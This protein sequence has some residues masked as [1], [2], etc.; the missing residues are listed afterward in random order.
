MAHPNILVLMADQLCQDALGCYGNELI[1]TPNIDKLAEA[2]I[3]FNNAYCSTPI[4]VPSRMSFITG[5]RAA[6]HHW[7]TNSP[8]PGPIPELPTMMTILQRAGYH[9]QGIG[10]M[11]FFG[12]MYGFQ[13]LQRMEE[14]VEFRAD[15]DY[16]LYLKEN[17]IRTR[18]PQGL[19]DLL[20]YQPQ[21]CGIPEEHSQSQ[22]V[23]NQSVEF[24]RNHQKQR[25]GKPFLLWSS[26][27]AP[28]PPFAPCEPYDQM[29]KPEDFPLP[30]N[31]ERPISSIPVPA[32]GHRSRLENA[33][34]DSARIQRIRALYAGQVSQVDNC[35]G[36]ILD[37]LEI[38]GLAQ[39]TVILFVSDHGD[40]LG[41][42]GLSQKNVPYNG[43]IKIPMLLKWPGKS[44]PGVKCENLVGIED[45]LP[46]IID[47]LE[48]E[49]DSGVGELPG[50]SLLKIPQ[51]RKNYVIDYGSDE[52]RWIA[53]I[54]KKHKYV[55]WLCGGYEELYDI[56]NDPDEIRNIIDEQPL[57]AK[58]MQKL[59]LEWEKHWGLKDSIV[60]NKF[61]VLAT[62][63]VE[64]VPRN[65]YVNEG[66]WP[67][68]LPEEEQ[69]SV[70]TYGEA[71]T[72]AI[73]KEAT[74]SPEKLSIDI[75]KKHGGHA[76]I[77]TPWEN[78]WK[79][80]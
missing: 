19:R 6:K 67:E 42:H 15:D 30:I 27:I 3:C 21:T 34:I 44:K 56:K 59:A 60:N 33:H 46:T 57:L 8:L 2:G 69:Q 32:H 80:A 11:H 76:L 12:R 41:N 43:S 5:Q 50:V 14:T 16:L 38:L 58:K 47:E 40:M 48:L 26:W 9:T 77:G 49:Y 20:Y 36:Q 24:L 78:S 54:N 62:S 61:K 25:T 73:S 31:A 18:Y 70:E 51:N 28:H 4:C 35:V 75:Y 66:K 52:N 1:K 79:E 22:W 55:F 71:F 64:E 65:V 17:G 23:A 39:N 10:K 72:R 29:Y 13:S 68:N 45:F 37:E 74:L 63:Q 53:V 7:V